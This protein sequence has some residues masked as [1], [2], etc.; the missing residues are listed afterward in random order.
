MKNYNKSEIMKNA[1]QISRVIEISFSGALKM[2][3]ARAKEELNKTMVSAKKVVGKHI[4][5]VNIQKWFLRKMSTQTFSEL[6][7]GI[8]TD[9]I[10]LE[11][12]TEK[13]IQISTNWVFEGEKK[14]FWIPKLA[15]EYV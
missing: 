9:D 14:Y 5:I 12:E 2:A 3:W 10:T 4:N 8:S 6:S 13:A 15:V 7:V 11:R 1:W